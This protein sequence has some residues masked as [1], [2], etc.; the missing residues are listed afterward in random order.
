MEEYSHNTYA[1]KGKLKQMEKH[2]S[3]M[4]KLNILHISVFPKLYIQSYSIQKPQTFFWN[5]KFS[6]SLSISLG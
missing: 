6:F 4:E 2:I 5:K 3:S 1:C